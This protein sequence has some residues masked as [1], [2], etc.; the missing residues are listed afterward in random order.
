MTVQTP[1]RGRAAPSQAPPTIPAHV[2]D[3]DV[4]EAREAIRKLQQVGQLITRALISLG[5]GALVFTCVNVTRF[6]MSHD[7]PWYVAWLLDPLASLA[8]IT[9]LYVDGILA[10]QGGYKASG[11][12]LILRWMAGMSTWIMNCWESL[13]PNGEV[14]LIPQQAD[15]GGILLHSVAPALLIALAE[16]SSGYR[17][18]LAVKLAHHR[19]ILAKF[20]EQ[21]HEER[22]RKE[23]EAREERERAQR[24]ADERAQREAERQEREAQRKEREAERQAEIEAQRQKAEI[25][26][27][28]RE[29]EAALKAQE[30]ERRTKAEAARIRAQGEAEATKTKAQADAEIQ[31]QKAEQDERER[32]RKRQEAR[33]AAERRRAAA[34]SHSAPHPGSHTAV[35]ASESGRRSASISA[36]APSQTGSESASESEGRVPREVRQK[37]REDAEKWVAERLAEG[38]EPTAAEVGAQFGKA[39]TWGGDRLR[40]VKRRQQHTNESEAG[41]APAA[42]AS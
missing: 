29:H 10:D 4:S 15:P 2:T 34:A 38:R 20:E 13:Y 39:E 6:G 40:A 42:V 12:P 23:R 30:E 35:A 11:W 7:I 17:K 1:V 22:K 8:L 3:K 25:D 32:E 14:T 16:A 24:E 41:A 28:N 19:A 36:P 37:Q 33:E 27:Q 21:Q 18:H 31:R 9:T 26:R 5:G